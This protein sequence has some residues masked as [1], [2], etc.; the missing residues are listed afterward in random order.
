MKGQE[1]H[2]LLTAGDRQLT[3]AYNAIR[4]N[5]LTRLDLPR[6][7]GEHTCPTVCVSTVSPRAGRRDLCVNLAMSFARLGLRTLL[8]DCDFRSEGLTPILQTE[9]APGLCEAVKGA[10]EVRPHTTAVE[11]LDF[12]PR[13]SYQGNPADLL[14]SADF[15]RFL[16]ECRAAYDVVFLALPPAGRYADL[17]TCAPKTEGVV[18]GSTPGL[19]KR[20]DVTRA[21]EA[22]AA[23]GAPL[24]GLVA[25]R[26]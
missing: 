4:A 24:L 18:L 13:G 7:E 2:R 11:G 16:A 12:L 6:I 3:E 8:V 25:R 1:Q 21:I 10:Q 14:G 9:M 22:L 19:D 23:V 26:R 15:I 5:L 20:R 17:A